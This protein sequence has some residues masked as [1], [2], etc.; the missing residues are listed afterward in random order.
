V[1]AVLGVWA[2]TI[3]GCGSQTSSLPSARRELPVTRAQA[4]LRYATTQAAAGRADSAGFSNAGVRFRV[5]E[6]SGAF[7]NA[8][9]P[10]AFALFAPSEL[11]VTVSS[12]S[13]ARIAGRFTGPWRFASTVARQQWQAAGSPRLPL[14]H[15]TTHSVTRPAGTYSFLP[16]GIK[17]TF[18]EAQKLPTTTAQIRSAVEAHLNRPGRYFSPALL[19]RAYG[20]LLG[21][22]PLRAATR[23]AIFSSI[24]SLPSV[25]AR[26]VGHDLLGR[27]GYL[28]SADEPYERIEL[29]LDPSHAEVL[30]VQQRV[31]KPQAIYPGL[32]RD[33]LVTSTTFV[34]Q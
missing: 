19:L 16:V 34:R 3:T 12:E 24:A 11:R 23:A 15:M 9:S 28:I 2:L 4:L 21:V 6:R 18:E 17:M 14:A 8:G 25:K 33:S 20:Y 26:G 7:M 22:A 27:S 1:L 32:A 30:A 5:L 29:L 13:S 31:L 10:H